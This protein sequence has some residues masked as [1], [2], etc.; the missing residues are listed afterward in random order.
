VNRQLLERR[1]VWVCFAG[2]LAGLLFGVQAPASAVALEPLLWPVLGLLLFS[3]FTQIPLDELPAAFADRRF[4][5]ALMTSNFLVVPVIVW[6]LVSLLPDDPAIRLG[7]AAVLLVPCTDWFIT[8]AHFG[9]GN[10][11]LAVAAAPLLLLVQ[12]V[13]LPV[14]LVLF[15]DGAVL[16]RRI[17][18]GHIAVAFATILLLPLGLAIALE[19]AARGRAR[20]RASAARLGGLA[21]PLLGVVVFVVAASQVHTVRE[22]VPQLGLAA[23]VFAAYLVLAATVGRLFAG[24]FRLESGA[25]RT[26][27]FSLGTRNSFVVLPLALALPAGWEAAAVVMVL[28]ILV[29]LLGMLGY[30]VWV[31]RRLL[32]DA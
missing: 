13:A 20:L 2:L 29:E 15:F 31:P 17:E 12:L 26:L 28:Q 27:V 30:L 25:A 21:V 22:S 4:L 1:Q 16:V 5:A 3:V 23:L 19:F 7:V 6:A 14:Y 11:K 32:P 8:F 24:L 10:S 18:P 9:R